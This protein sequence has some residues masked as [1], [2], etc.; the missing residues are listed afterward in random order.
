MGFRF[1]KR[2]K[3]FSGLRLNISKSGLSSSF[4][5]KGAWLTFGHGKR[6]TTIGAPGTGLSHTTVRS[7]SSRHN[8]I[9]HAV[10]TLIAIIALV[11][12]AY[13]LL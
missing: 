9:A 11:A 6:R 2:I 8:E 7:T 3:L 13:F 5:T 12:L 1:Q 4:G 10:G